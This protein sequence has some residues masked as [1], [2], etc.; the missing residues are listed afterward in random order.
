MNKTN[1][2]WRW[3]QVLAMFVLVAAVLFMSAPFRGGG[4]LVKMQSASVVPL[5]ASASLAHGS[6]F[7]ALSLS[8]SVASSG[9]SLFRSAPVVKL[10][11]RREILVRKVVSE[12]P[13]DFHAPRKGWTHLSKEVR[14]QLDR[15]A[16]ADGVKAVEIRAT[17][18]TEGDLEDLV[19]RAKVLGAAADMEQL[20][21][22]IVLGRD[23]GEVQVGAGEAVRK[24]PLVL[25]LEGDFN[26]DGVT[27]AQWQSMD[28]VFDY[29]AVKWG[30]VAV[31]V[32][33]TSMDTGRM[34][35]G[36]LFPTER[37]LRA[38]VPPMDVPAG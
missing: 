5:F 12:I 33:P 8:E 16:T 32:R 17:G 34:G 20:D 9:S 28:E 1:R 35:L 25:Y 2:S 30:K 13:V 14:G 27:P 3:S 23:E 29:L 19:R 24:G 38:L 18:T 10:V 21:G 6:S 36:A 11:K 15:L 7:Q 37:F 4:G 26:Q 22:A 31:S